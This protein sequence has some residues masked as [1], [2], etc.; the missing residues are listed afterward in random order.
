MT[1]ILRTPNVEVYTRYAVMDTWT[2]VC[3]R[4]ICAYMNLQSVGSWPLADTK[5]DIV[6]KQKRFLF[7]FYTSFFNK[8]STTGIVFI[9]LYI[10]HN[11]VN[12][13]IYC[14]SIYIISIFFNVK[15]VVNVIM[16]MRYITCII[17]D[18]MTFSRNLYD[19]AWM[20]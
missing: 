10:K 6:G 2:S 4:Y 12:N 15:N 20:S 7:Y 19:A 3:C 11:T 17:F 16:L 8:R 13:T 9:L 5:T 14:S 18:V 1:T